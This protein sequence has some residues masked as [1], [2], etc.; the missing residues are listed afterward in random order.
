MVATSEG[1]QPAA[2][3]LVTELKALPPG[4]L[5]PRDWILG[6][7]AAQELAQDAALQ[8]ESPTVDRTVHDL[9]ALFGK[10][11]S[12]V[13][14]WIERGDF[15]GSYKLN[16]KEWR[17]PPAALD[18]FQQAQRARSATPQAG[19]KTDLAAWRSARR[20][21]RGSHYETE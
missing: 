14:A 18:A 5:V 20:S 11:P 4:S 16:G 12:T 1:R 17:V 9:A 2:E 13:R 10:R 7:L 6:R 15:P 19:A 8:G 21:P 3:R